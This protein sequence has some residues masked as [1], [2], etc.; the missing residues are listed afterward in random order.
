MADGLVRSQAFSSILLI[1]TEALS[2]VADWSDRRTCV[3]FGDGA[4]AALL[5]SGR[6]EEGVLGS[7][8]FG[9]SD[10]VLLLHTPAGG[11]RQPATAEAIERHDHLLKMEGSGVFRSAVAMMESATHAALE[12][13]GMSLGDVDWVIPHQ[14]NSRIIDSLVKRLA[15]PEDRVV[16]NLDRVANT[17]AASIPIA[18]DEAIQSGRIRKGDVVVMTAFGAGVTY[19]AVVL[20]I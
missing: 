16:V 3:L 6:D 17:S 18:L 2:R 14:A 10:K 4:G 9:D 7:A 13:A 15:V 12:K 19:G 5:R 20:R 8:I 11:T 1:G